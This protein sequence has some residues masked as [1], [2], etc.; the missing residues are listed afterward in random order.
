MLTSLSVC[1]SVC[2]CPVVRD[3]AR[4]ALWPWQQAGGGSR[5]HWEPVWPR[6]RRRRQGAYAG[7][8]VHSVPPCSHRQLQRT[9]T[10][11][12]LQ[13]YI[14]NVKLST[15]ILWRWFSVFYRNRFRMTYN[16]FDG[17]MKCAGPH[18]ISGPGLHHSFNLRI[19]T[20]TEL[21]PLKYGKLATK[22]P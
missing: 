12:S 3:G 20:Y 8:R 11:Y 21:V 1:L 6:H 2:A 16:R 5:W 22:Y 18:V 10:V 17:M 4:R 7:R 9:A 15:D 13:C 19:E 14:Y